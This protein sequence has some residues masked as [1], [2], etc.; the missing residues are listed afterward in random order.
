ML[1]LKQISA[2]NFHSKELV[3]VYNYGILEGHN[4]DSSTWNIISMSSVVRIFKKQ[5]RLRKCS[6]E[7]VEAWHT[8]NAGL[9]VLEKQAASSAASASATWFQVSEHRHSGWQLQGNPRSCDQLKCTDGIPELGKPT[10]Q[11]RILPRCGWEQ[12]PLP[13]L[14]FRLQGDGV[15]HQLGWM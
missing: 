12:P 1:C 14:R 9:P 8:M 10:S 2:N 15:C 5:T 3:G 11:H 7:S 13:S 4:P 6:R